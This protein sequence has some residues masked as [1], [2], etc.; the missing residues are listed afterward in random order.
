MELTKDLNMR[1][2]TGLKSLV[3]PRTKN[4][5]ANSKAPTGSPILNSYGWK[6]RFRL[7]LSHQRFKEVVILGL[8]GTTFKS[9]NDR[10]TTNFSGV[11]SKNLEVGDETKGP[12]LEELRFD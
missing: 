4:R 1:Q 7:R 6:A 12:T 3:T 2:E 8:E 9:T 10:R 11:P 5:L